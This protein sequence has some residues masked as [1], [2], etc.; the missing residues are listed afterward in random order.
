MKMAISG[1]KVDEMILSSVQAIRLDRLVEDA[2]TN[3]PLKNAVVASPQIRG[4]IV[5]AFVILQDNYQGNDDLV[6]ELQNFAKNEVAPYKY[7][8]AIE[9]VDSLPKQIQVK[10]VVLN[11]AMLNVRNIIK[12]ILNNIDFNV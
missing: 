11:Y 2:L 10:S 8:R 6:K 9:F 3:H 12:K 5:K 4:N 7:P 1:L